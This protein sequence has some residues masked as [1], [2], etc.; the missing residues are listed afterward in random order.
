[1]PCQIVVLANAADGNGGFLLTCS[2][3][4]GDSMLHAVLEAGAEFD[5][6]PAGEKRF[7]GWIQDLQ[8]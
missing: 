6:R 1:V 8:G 7:S 5:L 2:R 3:G 4:Y